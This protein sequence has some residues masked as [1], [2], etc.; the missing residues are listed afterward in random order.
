VISKAEVRG[1]KIGPRLKGS[2]L[3]LGSARICLAS[4]TRENENAA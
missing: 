1:A 4:L 3:V 2:N